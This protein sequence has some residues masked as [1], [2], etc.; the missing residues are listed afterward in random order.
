MSVE[1][2]SIKATAKGHLNQLAQLTEIFCAML[3]SE[4]SQ[5]S[6]LHKRLVI[7][8][9]L[10]IATF[11]TIPSYVTGQWSWE[12]IPE[13]SNLESLRDLQQQGLTLPGW[14]TIE[15]DV[16]KI[17]GHKWSVQRIIPETSSD[18][19]T[20]QNTI[21]VMLRPQTQDRDLP[22]VEWM[23]INGAYQWRED[24]QR[25]LKFSIQPTVSS[26]LVQV[27]ARFFRGWTEQRTYAVVQWYAWAEGGSS[28]PSG[29]FWAD[30]GSQWRDRR[31]T[32]WVAVSFLIPI[33]PIGDIETARPQAEDLAQH[34][35]SALIAFTEFTPSPSHARSP[36]STASISALIR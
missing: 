25:S 27:E 21:L 22:Q 36:F 8:F 26:Q 3:S 23:D 17:G 29:W 34:I 2:L 15:Q 9:V 4:S 12:K 1:A 11:S 10:A 31:H 5:R 33:E 14:K 13:L 28:A 7:L 32:A 30:Q 16:K 20:P 35:Q 24:S 18:V 6:P 19:P